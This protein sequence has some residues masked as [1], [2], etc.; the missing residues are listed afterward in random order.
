M[1]PARDRFP[2]NQATERPSH[3]DG[4]RRWE[5]PRR[6]LV[7]IPL[8]VVATEMIVMLLLPR[9]PQVG[10]LTT[11]IVNA[12]VLAAVL[13]PLLWRFVYRPFNQHIRERDQVLRSLR[14]SEWRFRDIV[15]SAHEWIWEVD[16]AGRYTY[17]S[18]VV[19]QM[20]G[21]APEEIL[22]M[23]FYDLSSTRRSG[24]R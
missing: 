3:E 13:T 15:E 18:P 14:E 6:L 11:A 24:R 9:L 10:V 2:Q 5:S 12:A 21:Y 16:S 4:D 7:I 23:H 22:K 17:S 20:L 8:A 19:R 1:T